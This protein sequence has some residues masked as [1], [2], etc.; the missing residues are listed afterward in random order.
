MYLDTECTSRMPDGRVYCEARSRRT[1]PDEYESYSYRFDY[2]YIINLLW[3][4]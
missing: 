3:L 4:I 1:I 2:A